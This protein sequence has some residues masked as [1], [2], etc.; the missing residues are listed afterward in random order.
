MKNTEE[1]RTSKSNN[2]TAE[3]VELAKQIV[4]Q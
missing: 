3:Y 4:D 1:I 2:K